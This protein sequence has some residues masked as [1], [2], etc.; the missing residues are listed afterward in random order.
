MAEPAV[1]RLIRKETA[2]GTLREL[3]PPEEHIGL[4]TIA[5]FMDVPSDDVIFDYAKGLTSGLAP[6]RSQDAESELAQKDDTFVGIGR[7]SVIDW[8]LK[9]HYDPSDVAN[10]Q[11]YLLLSQRLGGNSGLT[12]PAA[13]QGQ[14]EQLRQKFVRDDAMRR[15]KIDN[16]MEWLIMTSL[17]T[18]AIAY[19][20]GRIRFSIDWG[21]PG[22]QTNAA[23]AGGLWSSTASDP[24]GDIQAVQE[25]MRD[26]Y[27]VRLKRAITSEKVLRNAGNSER[28]VARSGLVGA[29]GS[30]PID[31]NYLG[32]WSPQAAVTIIEN[33][34]GVTFQPY[35]AVYRTRPVGSNTVTINRFMPDNVIVFL[36][37]P[38]DLAE[39]D[40]A[41]GFSR[42]LTSPH[43][44]GNWTPGYY[45]WEQSTKDPW[46]TDRGTGIKAFP[47]FPHME[48][49]YSMVVL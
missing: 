3:E 22:G 9:D 8:A 5:P 37:D 17:A 42:T 24:I 45:E 48:M 23:P 41:I 30:A 43:P 14:A 39:L 46:G 26:T 10:Y 29:T 25:F 28:F 18:S 34:T 38:N 33:A 6:A 32:G 20:D 19:N 27:G 4:R 31:L 15:R 21:R 49:S 16:R 13:I 7:A 40:D 1:N 11:D 2:L 35:D 12:F 44:E 36:P 47:V